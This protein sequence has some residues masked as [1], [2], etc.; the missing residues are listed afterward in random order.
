MVIVANQGGR[1][2]AMD[3]PVGAVEAP[4]GVLAIPPAI[5]P[6][7]RHRTVVGEQL[8]ELGVHVVEVLV[9]VAVLGAVS[10]TSGAAAREVVGVMPVELRVVEEQL[11]PLL[12]ALLGQLLEH[13]ALVG[14]ALD[15]VPIAH[16]RVEHGEAI[17]VLAGDG[18]VFHARGLGQRHPLGG[19][20][21]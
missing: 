19:V 14:R 17:V 3:Q 12:A 15:D 5:E 20:E 10:V 18:D 6:D 13:V 16:L 4:V 2:Q 8:G 7:P 1:L 21:A 11:D 9:E